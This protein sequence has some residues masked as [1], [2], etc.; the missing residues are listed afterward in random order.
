MSHWFYP[1]FHPLLYYT[2]S[3]KEVRPNMPVVPV[4]LPATSFFTQHANKAVTLRRA[5]LPAHIRLRGA[6]CGAYTA[7][8]R[9][10]GLYHFTP[11]QYVQWL[12]SWR[13]QW[14]STFDLCCIEPDGS[15]PGAVEVRR[16]QR[17]TTE[18]AWYFW[19]SIRDTEW[20]WCPTIQGY[21]MSELERH[22]YEL[23]PLIRAMHAYYADPGWGE[24]E[25]EGDHFRVGIGSLCR[26][27]PSKSIHAIVERMSSIIG[28][29]ISLHLWGVKLKFLQTPI[30]LRGALSLDTGAWNGLFGQEHEARRRSGLTV[31]EYSWQV[32]QPRYA[33]KIQQAIEAPKQMLLF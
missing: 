24:E 4:L 32:S 9:W 25:G 2:V 14:A 31:V 13:P 30:Q 16:R 26:R 22:A 28:P 7:T 23:T 8:T 17:F 1:R 15:Y 3:A 12:S 19:E 10:K 27:L 6:D 11:L 20:C 5:R 18:M 29:D 21:T 33:H